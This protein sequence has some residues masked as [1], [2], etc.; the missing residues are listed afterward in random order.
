MHFNMQNLEPQRTQR[1]N[2]G[3]VL[4]KEYGGTV[5]L[6]FMLTEGKGRNA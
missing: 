2:R 1:N 6:T 4:G 3:H 5:R